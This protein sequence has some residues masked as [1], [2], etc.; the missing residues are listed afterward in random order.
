DCFR[1]GVLASVLL[2]ISN[3]F[4]G[5]ARGVQRTGVVNATQVAG[6]LAGLIVSMVM[7][8]AGA[9]LWAFPVGLL[10]RSLIAVLGAAVFV[11]SLPAPERMWWA[12]PSRAHARELRALLP[13]M[14]AASVGNVIANNSE[15]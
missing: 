13:S 6:A 12:R 8:V 3:G 9:G 15:I 14:S 2:L 1:V 7:L 4:V 10:V 5:L 11:R